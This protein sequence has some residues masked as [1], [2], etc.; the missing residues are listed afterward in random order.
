MAYEHTRHAV[1]AFLLPNLRLK[2]K[3]FP[4]RF[5]K[6]LKEGSDNFEVTKQ[7]VAVGVCGK[8]YVFNATPINSSSRLDANAVCPPLQ[9]DEAVRTEVAHKD[10]LD[11]TY[12]AWSGPTTKGSA[13]YF[14]VQGPAIV[15][16]YAPQSGTDHIHT[17]VRDP[18]DDYGAAAI[19]AMK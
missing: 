9:Q 8:R 6:Q 5:W 4:W 19:G 14:R 13:A 17:V 18:K 2:A 7:E 16:E 3:S 10:K 15:I 1:L 12:F 11:E